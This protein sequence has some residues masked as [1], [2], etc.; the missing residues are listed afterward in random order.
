LRILTLEFSIIFH[1]NRL[2]LYIPLVF[3]SCL[4]RL[5]SVFIAETNA[6]NT[7]AFRRII[8]TRQRLTVKLLVV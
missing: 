3:L 6:V 7:I 2:E 8:T 1:S 5:T 4:S